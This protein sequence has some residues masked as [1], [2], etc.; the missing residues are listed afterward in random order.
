MTTR[1]FGENQ[2]GGRSWEVEGFFSSL[3][4]KKDK[5]T[6]QNRDWRRR[7]SFSTNDWNA[8]SSVQMNKHHGV[9]YGDAVTEVARD[10][11]SAFSLL[12]VI[13]CCAWPIQVNMSTNIYLTRRHG[14]ALSESHMKCRMARIIHEIYGWSWSNAVVWV[15][16]QLSRPSM[17]SFG[18]EPCH[19]CQHSK[20]MKRQHS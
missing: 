7:V 19:P 8:A 2:N 18:Y 10:Q 12:R 9:G 5:L 3:Q 15:H 11:S 1:S 6:L 4:N 13:L 20:C 14:W 16:D 17:H